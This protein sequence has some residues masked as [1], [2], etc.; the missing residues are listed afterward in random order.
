MGRLPPFRLLSFLCAA[1][2][3]TAPGVRGDAAPSPPSGPRISLAIAGGILLA[4]GSAFAYYQNREA[5][6]DMRSYRGSA[7]TG[8]TTRFKERVREHERYT[9]AGV[10]GA[11][12]GG[13]LVVVSF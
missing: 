2:L 8:N 1:F 3:L 9:W 11:A 10:A 7:F 13:V 5:D 12:L 4:G 6:R